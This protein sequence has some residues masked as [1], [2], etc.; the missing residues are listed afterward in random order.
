MASSMADL[1]GG[2]RNWVERWMAS[3]VEASVSDSASIQ[4]DTSDDN[5][6]CVIVLACDA[7]SRSDDP[8]VGE[9]GAAAEVEVCE[10]AK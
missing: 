5:V 3:D 8:T 7:L 6:D 9:D 4:G 2:L 1:L 10:G